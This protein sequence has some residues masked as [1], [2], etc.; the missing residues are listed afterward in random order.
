[1]GVVRE[2]LAWDTIAEV[3]LKTGTVRKVSGSYPQLL[4]RTEP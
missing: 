3:R 1:M 2:K 4:H